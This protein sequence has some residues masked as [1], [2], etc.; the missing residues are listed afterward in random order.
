MSKESW[1]IEECHEGGENFCSENAR[2]G[3][4]GAFWK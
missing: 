1:R 4:S 2:S 3:I